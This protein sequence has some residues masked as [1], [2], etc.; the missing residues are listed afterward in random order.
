V[1]KIN[2]QR[3]LLEQIR[4]LNQQELQQLP[5]Y[6]AAAKSKSIKKEFR[7]AYTISNN[8]MNE[9]Q[10]SMLFNSLQNPSD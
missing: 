4:A 1:P 5:Q 7:M 9:S 8:S 2:Q 3:N 6:V 10:D